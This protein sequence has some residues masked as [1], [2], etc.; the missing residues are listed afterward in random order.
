MVG[1]HGGLTMWVDMVGEH[2]GL[3]W[4][5]GIMGVHGGWTWWVDMVGGH[6]GWTWW[7]DISDVHDTLS[8]CFLCFQGLH[9]RPG[10]PHPARSL[11]CYINKDDPAGSVVAALMRRA[12]DARCLFT[13]KNDQVAWHGAVM[14]SYTK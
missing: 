10:Q 2:G 3:T 13:V 12:F 14:C 9:P 5:V 1:G 8:C 6:G 7:V 11:T 4:W